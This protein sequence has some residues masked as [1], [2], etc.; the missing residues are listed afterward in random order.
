MI[1]I[2]IP[3]LMFKVS[4]FPMNDNCLSEKKKTG[5]NPETIIHRTLNPFDRISLNMI[6][7]EREFVKLLHYETV[8]IFLKHLV[9]LGVKKNKII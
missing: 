7:S 9:Y 6:S 5:K 3:C 1:N 4:F 8:S 2:N